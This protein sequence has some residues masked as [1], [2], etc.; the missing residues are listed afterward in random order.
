MRNSIAPS[1]RPPRSVGPTLHRDRRVRRH[2]VAGLLEEI[3]LLERALPAPEL[4]RPRHRQPRSASLRRKARSSAY[5]SALSSDAR[6]RSRFHSPTSAS[7]RSSCDTRPRCP[8]PAADLRVAR[9]E[10]VAAIDLGSNSARVVVV[11]VEAGGHLEVVE[12]LR[13]PL[14]LALALGPDGRL[15]ADAVAATIAALHEFMAV[16]HGAGAQR[17]RAVATAA[18]RDARN[19]DA[20]L[21]PVRD[22]LGLAIDVI[23]AQAEAERSFVGAIYG[24][25]VEHGL[26]V[27]IGGGSMEVVHFRDRAVEATW[28][29]PFGVLRMWDRYLS[30]DPPGEAEL[31]RLA[32]D[33]RDDLRRAGV[34]ALAGGDVLVGTGGSVRNLA[35]MDRR[36]R[37]YPIHRLHGYAI[38]ARRLEALLAGFAGRTLDERRLL[39]GLNPDRADAIGA[40]AAVLQG[41]LD[42]AGA[43]EVLVAGQGIREGIIRSVALPSLPPPEEVRR[44]SLHGRSRGASPAGT[45][46]A[47]PTA[48]RRRPCSSR[49]STRR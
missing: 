46:S 34:P 13:T 37:P 12:E 10:R 6:R 36:G 40:G 7:T 35:K 45:R 47:R 16:A 14:R 23:D 32:A 31:R 29:F 27:D 39:P 1:E 33:V 19:A 17:I 48:R 42:A 18:L 44:A 30:D 41:V 20:I 3:L 38:G 4:R 25:P 22:Q 8:P 43:G 11:E 15:P 28:S 21:A 2:V 5:A 9:P 49:S 26:L 24:L